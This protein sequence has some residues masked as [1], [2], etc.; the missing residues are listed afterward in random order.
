[1][2]VQPSQGAAARASA[3]AQARVDSG[4][5]APRPPQQP[6]SERAAQ[7]ATAPARAPDGPGRRRA[8]LGTSDVGSTDRP[9]QG[10][11]IGSNATAA[12]GVAAS[13]RAPQGP[14][15][16]QHVPASTD[17][18]R[19]APAGPEGAACHNPR[20]HMKVAL[21]AA[22]PPH[23]P[24]APRHAPASPYCGHD[25]PAAPEGAAYHNPRG[26]P[27]GLSV[28]VPPIMQPDLF[29]NRQLGDDFF[30]RCVPERFSRVSQGGGEP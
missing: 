21:G 6:Q 12:C 25:A 7:A 8:P 19:D 29:A 5:P 17:R 10:P 15:P 11:N 1:M 13:T 14:A 4:A 26:R 16:A 18:S 24:Q 23:A 20:G 9:Q 22:A 28:F 27:D 2:Q 3:A 30:R